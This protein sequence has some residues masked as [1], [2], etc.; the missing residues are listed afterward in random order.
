MKPVVHPI[1]PP[2]IPRYAF[3]ERVTPRQFALAVHQGLNNKIELLRNQQPTFESIIDQHLATHGT[4]LS[5]QTI[6]EKFSEAVSRFWTSQRPDGPNSASPQNE[7]IS[8]HRKML[9]Y[10]AALRAAD[11]TLSEQGNR[12]ITYA[13]RD[14]TLA[15]REASYT[16]GSRFGVYPISIDDNTANGAHLAGAFMITTRDGSQGSE[17]QWPNG[18]KTILADES[19]GPVVLHTPGEGFEEFETPAQALKTL[20]QRIDNG[21]IPAKLLAE[22]LPLSAEKLRTPLRGDDLTLG[23]TPI[24]DDVLADAVPQLLERQADQVKATMAR[25]FGTDNVQLRGSQLRRPEVVSAMNEAADWTVPFDGT[26][27]MLARAEKLAEKQQPDWLK[28]LPFHHEA[29]YQALNDAV[30]DSLDQLTPKL[31]ALPTLR[32]YSTQQL[33]AA[34]KKKYPTVDIDPDLVVVKTTTRSQVHT[35]ARLGANAL[36]SFSNK[37]S[38]LTD[39]ALA[40]PTAWP[41]ADAYKHSADTMQAQLFDAS[42]LPVLGADFKPVTLTTEALKTLVSDLDVGG[43]YIKLL[44]ERMAPDAQQGAPAELRAAWKA[45]LADVMNEQAFLATLNPDAYPEDSMSAQWV[46]AVLDHPDPATR[47]QVAAETISTSTVSFRGQILDG[48]FT[49]DNGKEGPLVLYSPDAPDG[50]SFREVESQAALEKLFDSSG[51]STYA[52]KRKSPINPDNPVTILKDLLTGNK[53]ETLDRMTRAK[54]LK[55]PAYRTPMTGNVLDALYKQRTQLLIDKADFSSVSTAEATRE[56][57]ENKAMFGIEIATV[58]LDV[59]PVVGKGVSTA[60]RFAR[61]GLKLIRAPGRAVAGALARPGRM[62][63]I[64]SRAGGAAAHTPKPSGPILRPVS[65]LPSRSSALPTPPPV[66]SAGAANGPQRSLPDFSAHALPDSVLSAS[67]MR[68]D[69]TY[70]VGQQFYVRYTDG[71]GSSKVFEISSIYKSEGGHVRIIDPSSKKTVAF[72]G[73]GGVKGEW[74]LNRM[75][76]GIRGEE[77]AQIRSS[78][79]KRPLGQGNA[80]GSSTVGGSDNKRPKIPES[81]PGE[82]AA[83]D[84]PV[85]GKNIFYHYTGKKPHAAITASRCLEPSSSNLAGQP[86]PRGQRRHYFTDLAPQDMPTSQ[87][88]EKIFGRRPHGNA[89][90]K[91]THVYEVNTSGLNLVRSPDNPHIFYVDTPFDIPLTYR[92]NGDLTSRIISHGETPFKA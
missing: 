39:F 57:N 6:A 26:N 35:G 75:L 65:Q 53:F 72:L 73:E 77:V 85:K 79:Q 33:T 60:A 3:G 66:P 19:N 62:A 15:S 49:I 67:T 52:R 34:L 27:A 4:T 10:E 81:F 63:M 88:S 64:Y 89:L 12:L 9:S 38:S 50:I 1:Y 70:Q 90:D 11:G 23:F 16:P 71:T 42:G 74:R 29:R 82:K 20:A 32:E 68:A 17:P 84:P 86:L 78:G 91:M 58:F 5:A 87:I 25:L 30:K 28:N 56:S 76:G 80:P 44:K 24:E 83:M 48:V 21:G 41:A 13:L 61:S 18:N 43:N 69:G 37:S 8:D 46:N 59:L 45:N 40:N 51:W 31:E 47:P 54:V 36:S 22:S 55:S 7:L 92:R 2:A 14:P